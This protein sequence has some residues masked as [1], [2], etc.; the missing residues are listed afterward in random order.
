[1]CLH[2]VSC[3][4]PST[5]FEQ[6]DYRTARVYILNIP[7]VIPDF[8]IISKQGANGVTMES[9]TALTSTINNK[10]SKSPEGQETS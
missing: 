6:R 2:S 5:T 3:N 4:C 7:N 10:D 1:M 8:Q 9:Q